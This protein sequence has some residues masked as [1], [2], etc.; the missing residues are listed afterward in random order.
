MF[1]EP[2]V[3]YGAEEVAMGLWCWAVVGWGRKSS[4][5]SRGI[6]D[7]FGDELEPLGAEVQEEV[8]EFFGVVNVFVVEYTEDI[9]FDVVFFEEV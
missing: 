9:I 2:E 4:G 7:D 6:P 1:C 3:E 5:R 8:I